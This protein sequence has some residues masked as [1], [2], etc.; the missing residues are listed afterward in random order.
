MNLTQ[1]ISVNARTLAAEEKEESTN[2][3][4]NSAK[5]GVEKKG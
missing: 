2:R 5:R 3:F 1:R 4:D